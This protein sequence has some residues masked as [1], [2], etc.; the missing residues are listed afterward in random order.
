MNLDKFTH[1][2]KTSAADKWCALYDSLCTDGG[3]FIKDPRDFL[4]SA[5]TLLQ[6]NFDCATQMDIV[7]RVQD[8]VSRC[9]TH[10]QSSTGFQVLHV[11]YNDLKIQSH[12]LVVTALA[13][14]LVSERHETMVSN[15]IDEYL[16]VIQNQIQNATLSQA[17]LGMPK[18]NSVRKI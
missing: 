7:Q 14:G 4:T 12:P 13:R 6:H 18:S 17:V 16:K 5:K 2:A 3:F 15:W 9:W 10:A 1:F 11:Y 8:Y